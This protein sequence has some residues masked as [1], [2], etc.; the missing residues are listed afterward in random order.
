[1]NTFTLSF[2][3]TELVSCSLVL[4]NSIFGRCVFNFE[5]CLPRYYKVP[6]PSCFRPEIIGLCNKQQNGLFIL[7]YSD[8]VKTLHFFNTS[9]STSFPYI[10]TPYSRH[11]YLPATPSHHLTASSSIFLGSVYFLWNLH[12]FRTKHYSYPL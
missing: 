11:V 9:Y 7:L 10:H 3:A 1:M 4:I 6:P 2:C 8:S 5:T 12:F